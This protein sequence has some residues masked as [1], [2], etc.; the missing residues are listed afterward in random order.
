MSH[1]SATL[2]AYPSRRR[3]I[4][5]RIWN[6]AKHQAAIKFNNLN[7]SLYR[8]ILQVKFNKES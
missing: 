3:K 8:K 1:I 6:E 7:E 5:T 2:T 4:R